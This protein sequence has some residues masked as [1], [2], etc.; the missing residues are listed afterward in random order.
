MKCGEIALSMFADFLKAFYTM[1]F[2][3]PV[4]NLHKLHFSRTFSYLILIIYQI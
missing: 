4:Q 3:I 1:D 2:N